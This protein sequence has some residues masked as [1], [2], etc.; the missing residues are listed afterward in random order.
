MNIAILI[1]ARDEEERI[2]DS[3]TL[4]RSARTPSLPIYVLADRC[5]DDTAERASRA[6]ARVIKRTEGP[7]GKGVAIAWF[8]NAA[9]DDLKD[10]DALLILDAD[11]RLQPG[12]VKA[13]SRALDEGADAAQAFVLP[14]PEPRSP[15]SMLS[16]FSEWT[17]QAVVDRLRR[18]LGAPVPLRGTGMAIRLD[19]L[20]EVAPHLRT[21]IEDAELTILL[22]DRR[23]SIAFV[24]EAVVEDPKPPRLG[25]VVRQRARWIQGQAGL[26]AR[27]AGL[28]LKLL[29]FRNI[30]TAWLVLSLLSKPKTA[31]LVLRIALAATGWL[32]SDSHPVWLALASVM[33]ATLVGDVLYYAIGYFT[34]PSPWKGPLLRA[35]LL[36]PLYGL[37]WIAAFAV[38][39]V[40]RKDWLRARE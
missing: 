24:P 1:A 3:I 22:L 40:S 19:A 20:R 5:S 12:A 2:A 32:L 11:S 34:T 23:R 39:L 37:I 30:R 29:C 28:L 15:A 9:S 18:R 8:L 21:R 35:I 31:F 36:S 6:N 25:G 33:T 26:L 4:V 27:H 14:V 38:G 16:A 17:A 10:V 13:L 7:S